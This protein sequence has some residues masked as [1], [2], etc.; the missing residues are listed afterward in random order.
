MFSPVSFDKHGVLPSFLPSRS[1]CRA[2]SVL[3]VPSKLYFRFQIFLP[4]RVDPYTLR[5]L[6]AFW[7]NRNTLA[8]FSSP[9]LVTRFPLTLVHASSS[10]LL[11]PGPR[12]FQRFASLSRVSSLSLCSPKQL[13]YLACFVVSS[14]LLPLCCVLLPRRR[15]RSGM[16]YSGL[17]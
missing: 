13:L 6:P 4:A 15:L 3:G 7:R 8:T 16:N 12:F 1:L 14:L 11:P 2:K 9:V 10:S 17:V 5:V